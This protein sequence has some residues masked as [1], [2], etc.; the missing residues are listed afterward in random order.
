M[1]HSDLMDREHRILLLGRT[2]KSFSVLSHLLVS[3]DLSG[4]VSSRLVGQ[5]SLHVLRRCL[6]GPGYSST[7]AEDDN[8]GMARGSY[9]AG[10]GAEDQSHFWFV[11]LGA[12][13][14]TRC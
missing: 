3:A 6:I 1:L 14:F 4:P 8:E 13:G 12:H 5:P 2:S 7:T 9:G 11:S 10:K